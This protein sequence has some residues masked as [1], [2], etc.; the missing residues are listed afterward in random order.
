MNLLPPKEN[1][2]AK[3]IGSY[4]SLELL[5]R[6]PMFCSEII[7][8]SL[9]L[10]RLATFPRP[11]AISS[12]TQLTMSFPWIL[13]INQVLFFLSFSSPFPSLP[14]LSFSLSLSPSLL[15]PL[16]FFSSVSFSLSFCLCMSMSQ[17]LAFTLGHHF[18]WLY[19]PNEITSELKTETMSL[20]SLEAHTIFGLASWST[21]LCLG[22]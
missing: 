8:P 4:K 13:S 12:S 15:F 18:I 2:L 10:S 7:C 6:E 11:L 9:A 16:L 21:E 3:V 20:S 19:C 17:S 22:S 1:I 14:F 5:K